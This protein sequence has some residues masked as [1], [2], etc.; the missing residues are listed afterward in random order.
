MIIDIAVPRDVEP[1]MEQISNVFL[2]DI[3]DFVNLSEMNRKQRETEIQKAMDIIEAEV[4]RFSSWWQA[5]E[6]KPVISSLVKKAEDIRQAQLDKTL[7]KLRQL[8][9]EEQESLEAMTK[10]MLQKILHDP[11]QFLKNNTHRRDEYIRLV[12]ELFRLDKEERAL[13]ERRLFIGSRGSK[14]AAV[15]AELVLT[16]LREAVPGLEASLAK[17]TTKGD[18]DDDTPLDNFAQQGIFVKELEKALIDGK[19]DLAVHSL[20]D[21]PTEIPAVLSLAAVTARIDPRD[22]LVSRARKLAELGTGS[23]IGTGSLR[24]SIQLLALRNDLR[25]KR[26]T[27][28]H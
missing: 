6:V 15:Q 16:K 5:N 19:I 10:A 24:R 11:I 28:K 3:D 22:V 9:A 7:K 25:N 14:L 13:N 27:R 20:K 23:K 1:E 18:R 17:I 4:D 2:Y 21:L 26:N 8:S 12:N